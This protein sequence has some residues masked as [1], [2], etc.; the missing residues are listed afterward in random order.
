M[1]SGPAAVGS[2]KLIACHY[3]KVLPFDDPPFTTVAWTRST[4]LSHN[5]VRMK[6]FM[7]FPSCRATKLSST[8]KDKIKYKKI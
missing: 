1:G 7:S 6:E 4:V 2:G 5:E 3:R 8:G